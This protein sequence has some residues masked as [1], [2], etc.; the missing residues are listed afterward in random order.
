MYALVRKEL[1]G[2]RTLQPTRTRAYRYNVKD[3]ISVKS[4]LQEIEVPMCRQ[5]QRATVESS[6]TREV[7]LQSL[8]RRV[9]VRRGMCQRQ[10]TNRV[11]QRLPNNVNWRM[12]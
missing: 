2:I 8:T 3:L 5:L 11:P 10:R 9:L 12:I 6:H 4:V 7:L 1:I